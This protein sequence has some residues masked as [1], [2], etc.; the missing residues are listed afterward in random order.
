MYRAI[1]RS[2]MATCPIAKTQA[3]VCEGRI[4]NAKKNRVINRPLQDRK[5]S[6]FLAQSRVM[7]VG[8]T[9]QFLNPLANWGQSLSH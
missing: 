2:V 6:D 9:Q 7:L 5:Q 3:G 8:I 1:A 4:S